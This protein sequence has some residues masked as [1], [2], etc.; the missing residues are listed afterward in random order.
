MRCVRFI[1]VGIAVLIVLV[2]GTLVIV[3]LTVVLVIL[4]VCVLAL[5]ALLALGV[6]VAIVV[7]AALRMSGHLAWQLEGDV[8]P[9]EQLS[10]RVWQRA[11][12]RIG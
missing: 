10:T 9:A 11:G 5:L 8:E 7:L 2:A 3:V 12:P 1:V 6:A 4:V